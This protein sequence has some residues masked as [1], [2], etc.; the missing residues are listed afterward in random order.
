[1]ADKQNKLVVVVGGSRVGK[2]AITIQFTQAQFIDEYDGGDT[3]ANEDTYDKRC[4]VDGEV[5]L[6]NGN[7][8]LLT[9]R[10]HSSLAIAT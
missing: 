10:V 3:T 1:M 2:S 5:A 8:I 9:I 4:V 6:L 7:L